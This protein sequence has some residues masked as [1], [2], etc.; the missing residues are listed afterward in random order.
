MENRH[1]AIAL[2]DGRGGPGG[3]ALRRP[4]WGC[5]GDRHRRPVCYAPGAR[6]VLAWESVGKRLEPSPAW[7]L[8][9]ND[10][11]IIIRISRVLSSAHSVI[12]RAFVIVWHCMVYN[13]IMIPTFRD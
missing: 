8:V 1:Q 5:G 7:T 11:N 9:P 2:P 4:D 13:I 3:L 6:A 10:N 12:G